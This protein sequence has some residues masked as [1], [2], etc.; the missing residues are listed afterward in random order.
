MV[1]GSFGSFLPAVFIIT[2]PAHCSVY[3]QLW[4]HICICKAR[5][6]HTLP[7]S[8]HPVFERTDETQETGIF[9]RPHFQL[10]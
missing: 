9:Q 3:V 5:H 10:Q 4:I 2:S 6:W 1:I 8:S 7:G